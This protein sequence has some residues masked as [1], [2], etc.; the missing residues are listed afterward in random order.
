MG[1]A[2]T[3]VPCG[4]RQKLTTLDTPRAQGELRPRRREDAVIAILENKSDLDVPREA[5]EALL[6]A[7]LLRG[8]P[9]YSTSAKTGRN[10]AEAFR[11]LAVRIAARS[12]A[13]KAGMLDPVSLGIVIDASVRPRPLSDLLR[14]TGLPRSVALAPAGMARTNHGSSTTRYVAE[15]RPAYSGSP[16]FK[17]MM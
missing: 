12:L 16:L 7:G 6:R 11:E 10:V 8:V 14:S 2:S 15:S 5:R 17:G 9:C 13:P 4:P 1:T 3:T